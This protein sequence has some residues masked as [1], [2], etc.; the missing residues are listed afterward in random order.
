MLFPTFVL[1]LLFQASLAT[2]QVIIKVNDNVFFRVGIQLQAWADEAQDPAT[3]GY[4]QNLYIRRGR[5]LVTG[6]VAPNVTFFFQTDNP[7][8]GKVPKALG[9]GFLLQDFWAQWRLNDAFML[10]GGEFL[11]PL[12]R[13]ELTSTSSFLTLDISP[14]TTVFAGPTQT[15]ATRDTG[16]QAKGYLADGR[17]EYRAAIFQGLRV[18]TPAGRNAFRRSAYGQYNFFEKETGYVYAG[19]NL[20]KKKIVNV[21]AGYDGQNRY[22]SYNGNIFATIPVNKGDEVAATFERSYYDG[23]TFI[24]AI[25]KQHD[26]VLEAGYYVSKAKVQPFVKWED[27]KF[28]VTFN[29]TRDV[30][31]YGA[32]LNY[33]VYGQNLKFTGQYLHVK[34]KNGA[35]NSTN[36][37]TVQMQMWYN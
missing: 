20:G 2:A 6:Q 23:G 34:P 29:P 7:N 10:S 9:S 18:G 15:N 1:L 11:V 4:V 26:D 3:K 8:V 24:A 14:T 5:F 36:Q 19:T 13:L 31:R 12:S 32:G 16:L 17:F 22:K 28:K 21:S 27:Q 35:I 37:F 25:P 30:T 33:Y